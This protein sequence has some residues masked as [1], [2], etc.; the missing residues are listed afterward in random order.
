M[1]PLPS[2]RQDARTGFECE[3][4]RKTLLSS[5]RKVCDSLGTGRRESV[6]QCALKHELQKAFGQT[7]I[8]EYPIPI[9]YEGERVG[10]SYIDIL[11]LK[12]G[13]IEVKATAKIGGKDVLQ[14]RAYARDSGLVGALVNFKQTPAG[15]SEVLFMDGKNTLSF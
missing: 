12:R 13:F 11:L 6:Y 4:T 2:Q 1:D 9:F 14:T 7:A 3:E 10:V 5:I 15:G 8:L